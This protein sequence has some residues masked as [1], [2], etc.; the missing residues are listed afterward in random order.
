MQQQNH[1][2]GDPVIVLDLLFV[3]WKSS[4]KTSNKT[5]NLTSN[6]ASN[7]PRN[8]REPTGTIITG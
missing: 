5:S 1:S 2:K 6:K 7:I 4:N 8:Q 3:L